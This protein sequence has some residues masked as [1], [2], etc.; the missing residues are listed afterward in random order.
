MPPSHL[1][2]RDA[3]PHELDDI[4]RLTAR[5][6]EVHGRPPATWDR[7]RRDPD[8]RHTTQRVGVSD[9]RVVA[10]LRLYWRDLEVASARLPIAVI[11]DVAVD[12]EQ[13]GRGLGHAMLTDTIQLLRKRGVVLARLAGLASFYGR[14]DFFRLHEPRLIVR[15]DALTQD[16]IGT[17]C[18]SRDTASLVKDDQWIHMRDAATQ[19]C[20]SRV[21]RPAHFARWL[22]HDRGFHEPNAEDLKVVSLRQ[23]NILRSYAI[24]RTRGDEVAVEELMW[25]DGGLDS[26]VALLQSITN[27]FP[28]TLRLVISTPHIKSLQTMLRK[29]GGSAVINEEGSMPL[30]AFVNLLEWVKRLAPIWQK[31]IAG[32]PARPVAFIHKPNLALLFEMAG[33]PRVIPIRACPPG[34]IILALDREEL[35]QLLLGTVSATT[36]DLCA[37]FKLNPVDA[38]Q[39]TVFFPGNSGYF[40]G[41][42]NA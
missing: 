37:R 2:I 13:Q 3:S 32:R 26:V 12:P 40:S 21:A 14:F 30:V 28:D 10:T 8:N 35:A 38:E 5:A 9:G 15:V 41:L 23:Q 36:L 29:R 20:A 18:V 25:G 24:C 6:F 4:V 22:L 31:Q 19:R 27:S 34:T 17:D 42:E 11:G 7:L 16:P 39:L 1:T 33:T